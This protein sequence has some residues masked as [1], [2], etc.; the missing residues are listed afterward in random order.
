MKNHRNKI[1]NLG[2]GG[3]GQALIQ[4]LRGFGVRIIGIKRHEPLIG[5][6]DL[7]IQAS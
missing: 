1:S 5:I 2:L 3:I 7:K 4:R 6:P